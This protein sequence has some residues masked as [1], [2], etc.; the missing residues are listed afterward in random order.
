VGSTE[1]KRVRNHMYTKL[2]EHNLQGSL[3]FHAAEQS[4][5]G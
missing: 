5:R 2:G 4:G 3:G 1:R